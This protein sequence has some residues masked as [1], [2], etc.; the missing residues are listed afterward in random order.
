MFLS[1]VN[2][3]QEKIK[4]RMV[5]FNIDKMKTFE[6]DENISK[7]TVEKDEDEIG[8]HLK[9]HSG[10]FNEVNNNRAILQKLGEY[11]DS[12]KNSTLTTMQPNAP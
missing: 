5:D 10:S 11:S 9:P 1:S 3:S 8:A 2:D 6:L 4:T 7:Q 12:V